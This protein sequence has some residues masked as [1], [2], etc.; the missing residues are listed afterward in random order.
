MDLYL[1]LT[2]MIATFHSFSVSDAIISRYPNIVLIMSDH[3]F[4]FNKKMACSSSVS[5]CM[6][7]ASNSIIKSTVFCFPYLKVLI[8]Y[9]VSAVFVLLLNVVLISLTKL[10]QS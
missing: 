4:F 2:K 8:F 1:Y 5:A 6:A 9:L 7:N 3:T 10:F